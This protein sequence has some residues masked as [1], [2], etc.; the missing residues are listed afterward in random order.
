MCGT[1]VITNCDQYNP[2]YSENKIA[3]GA[4]NSVHDHNT[5]LGGWLRKIEEKT[6]IAE[7][8]EGPA[9]P[10]IPL[11]INSLMISLKEIY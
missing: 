9:T 2:Q 11:I 8:L 7:S 1:I 5:E 6:S 3:P 10:S 4:L